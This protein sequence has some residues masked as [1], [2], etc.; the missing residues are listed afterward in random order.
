MK[1]FLFENSK[2]KTPILAAFGVLA[3]GLSGCSS[4][5]IREDMNEI[6]QA[7]PSKVYESLEAVAKNL[8]KISR[9]PVSK[10]EEAS[11]KITPKS[12]MFFADIEKTQ[13]IPFALFV[14]KSDGEKQNIHVFPKPAGAGGIFSGY[15]KAMIPE[16]VAFSKTG[17]RMPVKV[18][19]NVTT[20]NV[21]IGKKEWR[22][23]S[24]SGLT[25]G[26]AVYL[27]VFSNPSAAGQLLDQNVVYGAY[28][29]RTVHNTVAS[30]TGAVVI[31]LEK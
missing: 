17:Q 6:A 21:W 22:V 27:A 10:Q 11:A 29:V 1:P 15:S 7:D 2:R 16:I 4:T 9:I 12:P 28:G 5:S 31:K 13:K 14:F 23:F 18:E 3:I 19:K 24:L 8:T 26:E 25:P 20:G 30:P